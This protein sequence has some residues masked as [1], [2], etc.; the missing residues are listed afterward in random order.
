VMIT[1]EGPSIR[2]DRRDRIRFWTSTVVVPCRAI[3]SRYRTGAELE[4]LAAERSQRA[5]GMTTIGWQAGHRKQQMGV[6]ID[7]A[8]Q[9]NSSRGVDLDRFPVPARGFLDA[10]WDQP[11]RRS[12]RGLAPRRRV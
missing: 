11:L 8:G 7:E 12:R 2:H 5:S 1:P 3:A 6:A 9:N 4:P 10:G